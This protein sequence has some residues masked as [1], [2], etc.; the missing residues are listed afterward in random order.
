M[1][2]GAKIKRL[3][4]IA[5]EFNVGINT[6]VDYLSTKGVEIESKPNTKI[7]PDVYNLLLEEFQSEKS[8]KEES[9]KVT[10]G[11]EKR[12]TI[13]LDEVEEVV[14]K[15]A[16]EPVEETVEAPPVE[17]EKETKV[18]EPVAEEPKEEPAED[19]GEV[20]VVG[21]ID[22]E[23][24]NLKTRPGKKAKKKEEKPEEPVKEEK[25]EVVEEKPVAEEEEKTVPPEEIKVNIEK[26]EGPKVLGKINLPEKKE[27]K[28]KPVASS[29]N[30]EASS[31]K[32]RKR[33][34][35]KVDATEGN[36]PPHKGKRNK[37][38]KEQKPEL[39]EQEV[40]DQI[41]ETLAR[42][43]GGG[44]SKGA[45]HRR[46]K[47]Q[48]VSEQMQKDLAEQEL[49]KKTI[50]V[51]EFVTVSELASMMDIGVNDVIGACMSL[52]LFVSINQRL[53]AETLT[54]IAEEYG[55]KVEFVSAA[56]DHE[57]DLDQEDK[58]VAQDRIN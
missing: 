24:L 29:S 43:T 5:R 58:E 7:E 28:A 14:E 53:D 16:E 32:K 27:P 33:I 22:L 19:D 44:K 25:K 47:R 31:K 30:T 41:K 18:E 39:S 46:E 17:E 10:I 12:E 36:K 34:K 42:L 3:S 15:P 48:A 45:K 55:F 8:A 57:T 37:G 4:K 50:K 9:K 40:Q 35:R 20:K 52:G 51:T 56:E 13:T 26:L 2:E 49:E 21:K 38:K 23:S 6:L 1:S 54:I 11:Q